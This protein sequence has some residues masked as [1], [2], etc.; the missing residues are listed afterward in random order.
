G[1]GKRTEATDYDN[2]KTVLLKEIER[3][4]RPEFINRLDDIIVFRPLSKEDITSIIDYEI[5]KLSKRLFQ[6]GYELTLDAPAKE[7]LIERG[8]NP[9]YGARPL[10]RAIGQFVEDPLSEMLLSGSFEAPSSIKITR[11]NGSDGKPE[12]HLYFDAGPAS[13]ALIKA[14]A[15]KPKDSRSAPGEKAN[16]PST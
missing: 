10:R 7:F 8:Y 15:N 9:E 5:A 14:A 1:F 4:F 2:I 3:F 11:R 6:Q 16:A 12:D 13:E